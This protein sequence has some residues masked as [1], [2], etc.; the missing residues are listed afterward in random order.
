VTAYQWD[1]SVV[2]QDNPV[3]SYLPAY[4]LIL[5]VL[6]AGAGALT[7]LRGDQRWY[8]AAALIGTAAASVWGLGFLA[9]DLAYREALG[10][11][12]WF[13]LV[14]HLLLLLAA[15][16]SA[17]TVE[18]RFSP[19]GA[20]PVAWLVALLG[21]AGAVALLDYAPK[22]APFGYSV[23]AQIPWFCASVMA[24]VVP[25]AAALATPRRLAV[26]VLAGWIGGA[27]GVFLYSYLYITGKVHEGYTDHR[28]ALVTFGGTLLALLATTIW[29][30]KAPAGQSTRT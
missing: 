5:A 14:A 11:G 9:V 25:A 24:L 6:A 8:G 22:L 3:F 21:L 20:G 7:L 1:I 10:S 2:Q 12:V 26:A 18:V 29:Y 17:R 30:A 19:R 28:G 27:A 16:V 23:Q 15:A 13:L 4:A